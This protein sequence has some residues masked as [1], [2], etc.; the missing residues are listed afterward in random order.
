MCY[1]R[2]IQDMGFPTLLIMGL[3]WPG[4]SCKLFSDAEH[5]RDSSDICGPHS[6]PAA[7]PMT[8]HASLM[9]S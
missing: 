4:C 5:S 3:G 9:L 1:L 6:T 7:A 2:G 8:G